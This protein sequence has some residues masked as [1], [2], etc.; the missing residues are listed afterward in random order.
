MFI[1]KF[2]WGSGAK[3]TPGATADRDG[4]GLLDDWEINGIDFNN[5]GIV[6]VDLPAMGADPDHKDIFIE[7]DY[8]VLAGLGG[9][10]HRPKL[11]A[12][13]IVIDAFN[14]APVTNHDGTTGI[15]IHIDAGADTIMN[16]VTGALWG[17]R[18]RSI[19]SPT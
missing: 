14:N 8:M 10:T 9:H 11:D 2:H 7:I 3:S 5:D 15:H 13:Q 12:L 4:D 16:P 6:G 18:S 17:S 19:D 1:D